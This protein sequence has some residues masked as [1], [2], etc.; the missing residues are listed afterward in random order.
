MSIRKLYSL[1]DCG[2]CGAKNRVGTPTTKARAKC[3][4]CGTPLLGGYLIKDGI[5]KKNPIGPSQKKDI[6]IKTQ[7]KLSD[8]TGIAV[9]ECFDCNYVWK[10][11]T[12]ETMAMDFCPKCDLPT[13]S[14]GFGLD[15]WRKAKQNS[16][17]E[18][19]YWDKRNRESENF[20][21]NFTIVMLGISF[22]LLIIAM[23]K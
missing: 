2:N 1:A 20:Q 21:K 6:K 12:L 13:N 15:V 19:R 11:K 18:K 16:Q 8:E 23:N 3:G 7:D 22:L 14:T 5:K 17:A 4:S 10:R 9:F